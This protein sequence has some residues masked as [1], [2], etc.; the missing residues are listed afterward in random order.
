M[1][2]MKLK[3]SRVAFAS[4]LSVLIVFQAKSEEKIIQ[5]EEISFEKCLKVITTSEN[6]LSISPQIEDHSD[7]KRV[8][9]FTLVDGTLTITCNG[10]ENLVI[11]T[12]K[13]K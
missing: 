10:S 6:K 11:V 3:L 4:L 5:R 13:T 12:T 7:E 9:V 1:N 2:K 8:A